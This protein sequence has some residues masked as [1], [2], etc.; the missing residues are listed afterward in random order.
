VLETIGA[1]DIFQDLNTDVLRR[2]AARARGRDFAA[3]EHLFRRG[4]VNAAMY[5]IERGR[6]QVEPSH[7]DLSAPFIPL[8]LG[9]GDEFGALGLLDAEPRRETVTAIEPVRAV[10]L[11][12][13]ALA[14]VLFEAPS[15]A[16]ELFAILSHRLH[17][18][19]EL[20][21]LLR[22]RLG[23]RTGLP[24]RRGPPLLGRAPP[25]D[26]AGPAP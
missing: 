19:S 9:P 6:V 24:N 7:P 18:L 5:V 26:R 15:P 4:E 13:G 25:R 1:A 17:D 10:E 8:V 22:T 11:S 21:E 16:P 3:G 12:A 20:P 2:L 23:T 14:A